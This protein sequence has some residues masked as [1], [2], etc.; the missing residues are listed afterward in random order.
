MPSQFQKKVRKRKVT[1]IHVENG[2]IYSVM[3][4]RAL[5]LR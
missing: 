4:Q 3:L 5:S 1:T 2:R